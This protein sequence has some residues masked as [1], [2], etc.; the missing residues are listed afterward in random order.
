MS[1]G[2]IFCLLSLV[3]PV[4]WVQMQQQKQHFVRTT[5]SLNHEPLI[6]V[7]RPASPHVRL[8]AKFIDDYGE[9]PAS[10]NMPSYM[11]PLRYSQP[12]ANMFLLPV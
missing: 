6:L 1:S 10:F 9:D 3:S 11:R 12:S 5:P 7:E 2:F 8:R 4:H